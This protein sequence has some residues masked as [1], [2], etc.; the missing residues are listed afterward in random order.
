MATALPGPL[1]LGLPDA[2]PAERCL[3]LSLETAGPAG[4]WLLRLASG[5][6]WRHLPGIQI[7]GPWP[8][9]QAIAEFQALATRLR[10]LGYAEPGPGQALLERLS[11]SDRRQRAWAAQQLAW[12][13]DP[14]AVAPL[15]AAAAQ[16]GT[17]LPV[18]LDAL[19]RLGATAALPLAREQA[20]KQLLSRRR[21]GYEALRR[22][23]DTSGLA[24]AD[25]RGLE[26]LPES[27]R[28]ALA[29][30]DGQRR[31]ATAVS[32]LQQ[33]LD[34]L[35]PIKRGLALDQLYELGTPLAVAASVPLL[36]REIGAVHLW[37]YQKS[38]LKRAMLR[39]D[40]TTF[41]HLA[42]AIERGTAQGPGARAGVKS[43]LTGQ[44]HEVRLCSRRTQRYLLRRCRR[45]LRLLA[46]ND[47]ARF[48]EAAVAL[49]TRYG[50]EDARVPRGKIPPFGW[51]ALLHQLLYAA[52]DRL[53]YSAWSSTFRPRVTTT[54]APAFSATEVYAAALYHAQ[55][56]VFLKLAT[57]ALADVQAFAWP[58]LQARPELLEAAD[59]A[60]LVALL[61]LADPTLAAMAAARVQQRLEGPDA[62][63]ELLGALL[64]GGPR[65]QAL[66]QQPLGHGA[67]L[68]GL[69]PTALLL[70]LLRDHED[71][72][73]SAAQAILTAYA[74]GTSGQRV[75]LCAALLPRLAPERDSERL[76][77]VRQVLAALADSAAPLLDLP[78]L[79]DWIQ[80]GGPDLQALAGR[81]LGLHPHLTTLPLAQ[82]SAMADSSVPAV[83]A[84]AASGMARQPQALAADPWPLLQLAESRYLDNRVAALT[85]LAALEPAMLGFDALLALADSNRAELQA[86]VCNWLQQHPVGVD[87]AR[88]LH[89]LI[90][91]P[92]PIPRAFVLE[93]LEQHW[94]DGVTA[95][96]AL[97]LFFRS[98]L[99]MTG[100]RRAARERLFDLLERRGLADAAQAQL[101]HGWL[102]L[103]LR[104]RNQRDFARIAASLSRLQLAW[105]ALAETSDW[106]LAGDAC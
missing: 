49:L 11:S 71:A 100:L 40:T 18:L 26:R 82:L 6:G 61:E 13:A 54:P 47:P 39:D 85:V 106:Q 7:Y 43:G 19:A 48:L 28:S 79:L 74:D 101:V 50:P 46:K 31:D 78:A 91:H 83:R 59:A 77:G 67:W 104:T 45:Y 80:R 8:P 63:I 36:T 44:A 93:L 55:P 42:L 1:R 29:A 76:S 69:R 34:A 57:A 17:E 37:R 105:P 92:H 2:A 98:A 27:V 90:E 73:A 60:A 96:S 12:C 75:Q 94:P 21:S 3:L 53:R 65:A 88:L 66:A 70:L 58:A 87:Q 86:F 38:V 89:H 99:L 5:A 95:L 20:A 30:L 10:G 24:E 25:L 102:S 32:A 4:S 51:C 72:R 15:L 84:A 64:D 81:L 62:D 22:L 103:A 16:A 23:G 33:A 41:A 97:D 56:G 9:E 14:R 68:R 35:E 52:G